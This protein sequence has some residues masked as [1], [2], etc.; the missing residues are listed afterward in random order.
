MRLFMQAHGLSF[1]SAT[2]NTDDMNHI[3]LR[4]RAELQANAAAPPSMTARATAAAAEAVAAAAAAAAAAAEA[5]AAAA[6]ARA[7][8]AAAWQPPTGFA[9]PVTDDGAH[10]WRAAQGL[11][12][13][14]L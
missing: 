4:I 12:A 7:A 8:A 9:P 1:T 10:Y 6:A 14:E 5:A 2:F 3:R 13:Q 11:L